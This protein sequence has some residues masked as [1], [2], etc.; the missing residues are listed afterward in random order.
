MLARLHVL[1]PFELNIPKG[2]EFS[3]AEIDYPELAYKVRIFPPQKSDVPSTQDADN[4]LINN[5]ESI[6]VNTLRIDFYKEDFD[7]QKGIDCDPPFDFI[8]NIINSFLE[9]LRF[10]TRAK[11]IRPINFPS[12]SWKLQYLNDDETEL[13]IEEGLVR[14]RI[15]IEYTFKYTVLDNEVWSNLQELPIDYT[16]PQWVSLLLDANDALPEI[17][18]AVVL[19]ETALEVFISTILDELSKSSTIPKDIWVWL[20]ERDWIRKPA[21]DEQ[22]GVLLKELAGISL[23]DNGKLWEA[24]KNLKAARNSFVHGG[25]AQIGNKPISVGKAK[26]LV[27]LALEIILWIR[28]KLPD[29]LQWQEYEYSF[30]ITFHKK[31]LPEDKKDENTMRIEQ[32]K[33]EKVCTI[34]PEHDSAG[35]IKVVMPQGRYRNDKDL[36]LHPYGRGPFCKFKIPR[37]IQKNGVYAVVVSGTLKYIGECVNLSSRYN[38]GYGNISPRNCFKGGQQPNCRINN[39]IYSASQSGQSIEVWFHET[40]D[41]KSIESNLRASQMPEWNLV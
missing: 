32:V 26:E 4:I 12:G 11:H 10:V 28:E 31:I 40:A 39:L 16:P 13:E 22:F 24:F 30:K 5:K 14:R 7:R 1:L 2:E 36:P 21:V 3:I 25:I 34:K 41:H 18:T 27:T 33:F 6:Q 35:Q 37:N 19:A 29:N 23:K 20:N 8:R 17:G 15:G 9:K 38:M